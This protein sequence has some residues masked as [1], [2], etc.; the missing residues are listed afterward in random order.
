MKILHINKFYYR[1]GGADVYFLELSEYLE[2]RGHK[3]IPF[4]MRH[5]KNLDSP[6]SD[7]FV[8]KVDLKPTLSLSGLKTAGRIIYSFE[9]KKKVEKLIKKEKPDIVHI[10]N[11]YHQISPSILTVFKKYNLPVVMTVHDYKLICPNYTLFTQGHIC[12]K[13]KKYRYWNAVRYKCLKDSY[14]ASVLA[15]KEMYF[16]RLLQIYEKNIDLFLAPSDFVKNKLIEWGKDGQKI[17]VHPLFVKLDDYSPKYEDKNYVLYAGRLSEE[18]GVKV[19]V[20]AAK[21]LKEEKINFKIAGRGELEK[22]LKEKAKGYNNIEFLGFVDGFDLLK[23]YQNSRFLVYPTNCYEASGGLSV[24]EAAACGKAAIASDRGAV[25]DLVKDGENGLLFKQGD[26]EDLAEKIKY[27]YNDKDKM[28]KMGKRARAWSEN[29]FSPQKLMD[30]L[31][32]IYNK[33]IKTP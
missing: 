21:L 6:Y 30:D 1:H 31:E 20:E 25:T 33:L 11:I 19:L 27:L 9:A 16:H 23:T 32:K 2:K 14:L 17:L 5:E 7:Y 26:Y 8:S 18:K 4:A 22:E 28:V 3:V 15:C 12:E 13:C 10:H 24:V 29:N